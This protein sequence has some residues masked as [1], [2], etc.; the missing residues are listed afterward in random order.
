MSQP[1]RISLI[2]FSG[3]GKSTVAGL[4][5]ARLGWQ[6]HDS[7]DIIVEQAGR[8]IAEIF[9]T[10]GEAAFRVLELKA[11]EDLASQPRTVIATGGGAV[12]FEA[13]RRALATSGLIVCLEA[14][15][16]TILR[17]LRDSSAPLATRP[18]V[19][20][21]DP[22]TQIRRLKTQ[23]AGAYAL[24]DITIHTDSLTP[25]EVA[26]EV[27]RFYSLHGEKSFSR[28]GR[29]EALAAPSFANPSVADA[30]GATTI[31]R[32]T[33]ADYP[34]YTSWGALESLGEIT[35]R[36]TN[37]RRAFLISD[38]N[39]LSLWGES[40]I[41]SL[42]TAGLETATLT[43]T[44]GDAS[45]SL[46]NAGR[47]YDWLAEHRAERRDTI[48]ALG[49]GMVNDFAGFVAATYMRG[50]PVVQAPT[51]LLA[52]VDASIGGKTAINQAHAKNLVGAFYQPRA[53][54]ADVATLKT[55]PRRELVEG[56]GEVIKHALIRDEELLK[57]LEER[58]E[59]ILKLEP[60]LT[61]RVIARNIQ[62]KGEVVSEDE[63]ET[64]GVREILNYGH[65]LGH[66]FE[67]AGDY[68]ALLHGEAVSVGMMAA[69][70]IGRRVGVTPPE[71]V[72]RQ[73]RLLQRVGLPLKPPPE[74]D[75]ERIRGALALDK[76]IVAGGQRW[77][78]LEAVGRPIA[79]SDIPTS[80]VEE[81][82]EQMLS[83]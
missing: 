34:A 72:D 68:S 32:T 71:L 63:R 66:A 69:A 36:A 64:G 19:T 44:P 43:M 37:S 24:A 15:P 45:K 80:I 70:E 27:V 25:D 13:S 12:L 7:D 78:L 14:A 4:I 60:E 39:V 51:S 6:A 31:I 61:T 3:T 55:L 49:G 62:I 33:S 56:F 82:I 74:L 75:R 52:M 5:A 59:D 57:L 10:D 42:K 47:A 29:L 54:V 35:R 30:P 77:I 23:R 16:E 26:D 1:D 48:V 81:V 46:E 76:K 17:R 2:G 8:S 22:M 58:L 67:S 79:R 38:A 28:P 65:T 21:A 41:A 11:I 53:V 20:G 83:E 18:L 9:A 40:A 50:I 73:R